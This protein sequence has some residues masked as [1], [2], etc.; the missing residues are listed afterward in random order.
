MYQPLYGFSQSLLVL[1]YLENLDGKLAKTG[2]KTVDFIQHWQPS[3]KIARCA[4]NC[5]HD[6]L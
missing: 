2:D 1:H 6:F 5:D 4:W 3:A